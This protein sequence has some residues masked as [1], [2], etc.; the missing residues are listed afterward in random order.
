M[1]RP[2]RAFGGVVVQFQ[3]GVIKVGAKANHSGQAIADSCG[4]RA[5]PRYVGQL[6]VQPSLQAVEDGSGPGLP[7]ISARLSGGR[8]RTAFSTA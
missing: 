4:Q 6:G 7:G 2:H 8:S 1:R 3:D 5:F